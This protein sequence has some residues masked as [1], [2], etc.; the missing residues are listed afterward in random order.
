MTIFSFYQHSN[1]KSSKVK[2]T[3]YFTAWDAPNEVAFDLT[4]AL[5]KDAAKEG[6]FRPNF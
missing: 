5:C 4:K 1:L 6:H 3:P 2:L